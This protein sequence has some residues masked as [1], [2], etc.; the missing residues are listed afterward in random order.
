[1]LK[2]KFTNS[3]KYDKRSSI[4]FPK[5]SDFLDLY[6]SNQTS[7]KPTAGFFLIITSPS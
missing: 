1:M 3:T 7:D 4:I 5:T 6:F 2:P